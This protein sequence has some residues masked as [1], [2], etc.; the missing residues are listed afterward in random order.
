MTN[1]NKCGKIDMIVEKGN[2]RIQNNIWSEKTKQNNKEIFA[3]PGIT[4]SE[5]DI[6]IRI[7]PSN[8]TD[9]DVVKALES[10]VSLQHRY[11]STCENK[12]KMIK[13]HIDLIDASEYLIK[14]FKATGEIYCCTT[15]KLGKLLTITSLIGA[16]HQVEIFDDPIKNQNCGTTFSRL[17]RVYDYDIYTHDNYSD[18]SQVV[19]AALYSRT[20]EIASDLPTNLQNLLRNVFFRYAGYPAHEVGKYIDNFKKAFVDGDYVN[21]SLAYNYFNCP[22]SL[23]ASSQNDLDKYIRE[24]SC[25]LLDETEDKQ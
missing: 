7:H 2:I 23:Y 18:N 12:I 1:N 4:F 21:L 15:T 17:S 9:R 6:S 3:D 11:E 24:Y 22:P 8:N 5:L 16:K 25:N 20:M 13:W 19:D 10:P 14:L